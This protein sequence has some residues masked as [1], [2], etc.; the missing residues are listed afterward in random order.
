MPA[1]MTLEWSQQK[2]KF[3]AN[4]TG[5]RRLMPIPYFSGTMVEVELAIYNESNESQALYYDGVL[6]RLSG[7]AHETADHIKRTEGCEVTI[8]P[9]SKIT[10]KVEFTH[11]PPPGT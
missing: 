11:L 5:I 3:K 7:I 8:N 9:K 1:Y 10:Q 2:L 6:F 4:P